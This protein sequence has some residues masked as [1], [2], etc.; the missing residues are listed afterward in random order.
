MSNAVLRLNE[1]RERKPF[2][3]RD[4]FLSDYFGKTFQVPQLQVEDKF[5]RPGGA[6]M[7]S[8]AACFRKRK[9]TKKQ[10]F[11]IA[12]KRNAFNGTDGTAYE[13]DNCGGWHVTKIPKR[14]P[15]DRRKP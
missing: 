6:G 1:D 8:K 11:S 5:N 4:H 14:W 2:N 7:S 13:C 10:A 9:Y 15:L 12:Q 3:P